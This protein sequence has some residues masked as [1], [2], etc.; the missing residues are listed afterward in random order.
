MIWLS[1]EIM[2]TK[3]SKKVRGEYRAITKLNTN[4]KDHSKDRLCIK[5]SLLAQGVA[6]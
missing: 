4:L 1:R 2:I 3:R 5:A 6:V